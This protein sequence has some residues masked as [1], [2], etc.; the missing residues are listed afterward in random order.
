MEITRL[1]A[2]QRVVKNGIYEISL[3]RHHSGDLCDGPSVSSTG[4]RRI[5]LET[6]LHFWDKYPGNPD[7]DKDDPEEIEKE[8]FR[9]GRA[10]HMLL[11][12]PDLFPK[13]IAIRPDEY[14]SWRTKASKAWLTE[15]QTAGKTVL[16][17]AEM[18]RVDGVVAALKSHHWHTDGILGGIVEASII[19]RDRKTGIWL[20]SRPDSIPLQSAFSDLKVMNDTSP[21]SVRRAIKS[22]GYDLQMALAGVAMQILTGE[23]IEQMWI[24]AVESKRPYAIH[25][26][27]LSLDAIYWARMRLRRALDTMAKCLSEGY[28]P[29]YGQDGLEYSP[30][31]YETEQYVIDQGAGLLPREAEF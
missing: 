22:L 24:V 31:K 11:L 1:A 12:E 23:V 21:D 26:E 30:G 28:W 13:T 29:S 2:D 27:S 10:A 6:P 5:D 25:V 4:L 17:P 19:V 7:C 20:K 16:T 3:A 14:D 18:E 15:A 8:H 9:I